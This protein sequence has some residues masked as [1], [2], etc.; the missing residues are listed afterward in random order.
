MIDLRPQTLGLRRRIIKGFEA[1]F[2]AFEMKSHSLK[3]G[4]RVLQELS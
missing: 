4:N 2:K 3:A 1:F